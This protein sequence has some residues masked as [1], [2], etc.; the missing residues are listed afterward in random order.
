MRYV[1]VL[2][3]LPC[4][5][6]AENWPQ[7]R[8][9]NAQGV[10]S[11]TN[12]PT[13]WSDTTNVK[14]KIQPP[15]QGFSSPIIWGDKLFITSYSGYGERIEDPGDPADLVR[16]LICIDK[17]SGETL[18]KRDVPN[19]GNVRPYEKAM[20]NV[21]YAAHTP[22]TDGERV[23]CFFATHGVAVFDMDGNPLWDAGPYEFIPSSYGSA[24]SPV[25]FENLLIVNASMEEELVIAF[26]KASGREVWRLPNIKASYTTPVLAG[27]VMI[28][29]GHQ[30]AWAFDPKTGELKWEFHNKR[31]GY[32]VPV[33]LY[34]GGDEVYIHGSGDHAL[35]AVLV[36]SSGTVEA[37]RW[38]AK[39]RT[40]PMAS[41]VLHDGHIYSFDWLFNSIRASDGE[42]LDEQKFARPPGTRFDVGGRIRSSMLLAG[43]VVYMTDSGG[44]TVLFRGTTDIEVIA[45]N[46]FESEQTKV[47][48]AR[49]IRRR[50]RRARE[51]SFFA[52]G[53][54][55]LYREV[56]PPRSR[57]GRKST[58]ESCQKM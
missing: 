29:S 13:E 47:H 44:K 19:R 33:A 18:W 8:G 39:P 2:F 32:I 57:S 22:V 3:L 11:E 56:N 14:W 9:P 20:T 24:A 42:V 38:A 23:Y 21:G 27:K 16:H 35:A 41:G 50:S 34:D 17:N 37:P 48:S 54:A 58:L 31:N 28:V 26:D 1:S 12:F 25:V 45:M 46:R 7:F 55:H 40:S 6:F 53:L 4:L 10:A 49:C 30:R 52:R 36:N 43:D 51:N 5:G 15:G